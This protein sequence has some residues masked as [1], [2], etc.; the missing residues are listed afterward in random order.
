M[1]LS[2]ASTN[3]DSLTSGGQ[4]A[5]LRRIT[6]DDQFRAKLENHP[7]AAMAEYGLKIEPEALPASVTLPGMAS[8]REGL[9]DFEQ[10]CGAR[11][12]LRWLGFFIAN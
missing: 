5:F 8:L 3:P 4:L 7:Q 9:V 2:P 1:M 12:L 6:R 10:R 11:D